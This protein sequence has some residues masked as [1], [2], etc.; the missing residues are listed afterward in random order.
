MNPPRDPR[1]GHPGHDPSDP[2][3]RVILG[4]PVRPP[5]RE[6]PRPEVEPPAPPEPSQELP[7]PGHTWTPTNT[8]NLIVAVLGLLGGGAGL[9]E[10]FGASDKLDELTVK[11]SSL[12]VALANQATAKSNEDKIRD[13][14]IDLSTQLLVKINGSKPHYSWPLPP[15]GAWVL[16]VTMPP[17]PI[18]GFKTDQQWPQSAAE[19]D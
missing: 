11:V 2:P 19:K 14:K 8:L 9:R 12:E 15:E 4:A 16:P 3:P 18:A 6:L 10:I 7:K 13:R 1:T 17:E 5:S